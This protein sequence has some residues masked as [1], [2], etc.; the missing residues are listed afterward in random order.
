MRRYHAVFVQ[1]QKYT[2]RTWQTEDAHSLVQELNNKRFGTIAAMYS[3]T[4]TGWNMQKPLLTS[5]RKRRYSWFCIEVNGKAVGNIGFIPGTDV[6]CF[7]AEV[8][9]VIGEKYWN[10]GIVTDALQEAIYHYFT[11]TNT[12]RIFALVFEHNFP[13]MRVLEKAGFNKVGIMTNPFS[14]MVISPMP[15]FSSCLKTLNVQKCQKNLQWMLYYTYS[16]FVRKT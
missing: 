10:Q 5:S 8:G 9:Y 12:I 1:K 11:Y 6:E 3:P 13:S 15:I 4:L 16:S 2:L 14:R 7:N